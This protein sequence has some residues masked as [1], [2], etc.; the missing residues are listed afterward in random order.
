MKKLLGWAALAIG[1]AACGSG[2]ESGAG[3]GGTGGTGGGAASCADA[4]TE[5]PTGQT[6]WFS[7]DGGFECEPSGTGE[8]G[9]ACAPIKGQPTCT[10]GLICLQE[11]G[12]D[13]TCAKLCDATSGV[14]TCGNLYCTPIQAPSGAQTHVCH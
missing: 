1:I 11:P 4:P 13:G 8:E 5:C 2:S 9:D 3:G 14:N 6:C 10:D 7:L 12:K